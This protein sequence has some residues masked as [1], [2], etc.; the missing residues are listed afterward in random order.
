MPASTFASRALRFYK[1]L[2]RP[3]VPRGVGVMN[4]YADPAV[5]G[6]VR[7]FLKRYFDDDQERLLVLGINPGRFGAGIT[8]ITFTDPVAL[9]DAC[10]IANAM[11]RRRELSSIFVYLFIDA[12]GGP[13]EFYRRCFLT[14][15]SPLGYTRD[16]KN[17]NYYD[18]PKLTRAVTPFIVHTMQQQLAL[19]ARRD[20]AV[21]LGKGENYRYL[22]RMN[23]EHRWFREIHAL[24]HP[25]PIMQYRRKQLASYVRQYAD[26]ISTLSS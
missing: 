9:A 17:L 18:E 19:G 23:A 16:G 20:H 21:V 26:L 2:E 4:P 12:I 6:L 25:R 24:D 10:G 7:S 3:S 22:A 13:E 5:L 1:S 15:V 14:A 8:G 11:P